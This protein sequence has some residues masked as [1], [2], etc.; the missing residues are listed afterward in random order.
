MTPRPLHLLTLPFEIRHKIWS[1]ALNN[2]LKFCRTP[3]HW[4]TRCCKHAEAVTVHGSAVWK[5]GTRGYLPNPHLGLLLTSRPVYFEVQKIPRSTCLRFPDVKC[6]AGSTM[7]LWAH[8]PENRPEWDVWDQPQFCD[9]IESVEFDVQAHWVGDKIQWIGRP[10]TVPLMSVGEFETELRSRLL[11]HLLEM[12][13][14]ATYRL[15]YPEREEAGRDN[16][17][18]MVVRLYMTTRVGE[19]VGYSY[20]P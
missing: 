7:C 2:E 16:G 17:S 9:R 18:T 13:P 19:R 10:P 12:S 6:V 3:A 20:W 14:G 11:L 1:Y 8:G 4:K 5:P 15:Q